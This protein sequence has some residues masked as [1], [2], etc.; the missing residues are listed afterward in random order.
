MS[1][2]SCSTYSAMPGTILLGEAPADSNSEASKTLA[3]GCPVSLSCG[4]DIRLRKPN[5]QLG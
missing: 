2:E 5:E 3:S 4:I 1:D